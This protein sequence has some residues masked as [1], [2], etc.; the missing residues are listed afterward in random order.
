M[1]RSIDEIL[2]QIRKV[3]KEQNSNLSTFPE[4]GNLYVIFRSIASVISEQD[5]ELDITKDSLFLNTAT[6]TNLDRKAVE[7]GIVRSKGFRANGYVIAESKVLANNSFTTIPKNTILINP[8][9]NKQYIT[10]ESAVLNIP[11]KS[12]KVESVELDSS[13]NLEAGTKL[14]SNF[15]NNITFT[16]GSF[17]NTLSNS[18]EGDIVGGAEEESD[19]E[20]RTRILNRVLSKQMSTS[21]AIRI[22]AES[23]SGVNEVLIEEN[24]PSIGYINVFIDNTNYNTIN[25]VK[26]EVELVK[27]LGTI[28]NVKSFTNFTLNITANITLNNSTN[29]RDKIIEIR[30]RITNFIANLNNTFTKEALAGTLLNLSYISNVEIISPLQTINISPKEKFVIG[31]INI[32]T[33]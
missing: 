24:N 33:I 9:T 31:S 12:I 21:S 19:E 27:P 4:Y 25:L 15:F 26:Q 11:R 22:K 3:L 6:N 29:Q 17:Y 28:I 7:R 5:A 13:S 32:Q 14:L 10:L 1:S 18:Y 23:V 16:V 20:L 2:N 8:F 30:S